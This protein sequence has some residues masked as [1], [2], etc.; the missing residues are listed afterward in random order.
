MGPLFTPPP[1]PVEDDLFTVIGTSGIAYRCPDR[2]A[3]DRHLAD[4]RNRMRHGRRFPALQRVYLDDIDTLLDCRELLA[5]AFASAAPAAAA[6]T[7]PAAE[8]SGE[9]AVEAARDAA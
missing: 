9:P 2:G 8:P 7:A 5:M 4:L 3:F 6:A 1:K